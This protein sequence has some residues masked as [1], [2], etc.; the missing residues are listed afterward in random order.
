MNMKKMVGYSIEEK[1]HEA[2]IRTSKIKGD[3]MSEI[4]ESAIRD[5][6]VKN[7]AEV[8]EKIL[9]EGIKLIDYKNDENE[10]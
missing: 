4:V 1:L 2:F 5:Y 9:S 10:Q 3:T 6:V 8:N 7:T